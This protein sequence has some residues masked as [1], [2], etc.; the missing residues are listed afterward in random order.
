MAFKCSG[1]R[2]CLGVN[3]LWASRLAMAAFCCPYRCPHVE[4]IEW[5]ILGR[6]PEIVSFTSFTM[7]ANCP[8]ELVRRQ[9]A[10]HC[11]LCGHIVVLKKTEERKPD[12]IQGLC[13]SRND[14]WSLYLAIACLIFRVTEWAGIVGCPS[15]LSCEQYQE[16]SEQFFH[17]PIHR[18]VQLSGRSQGCWRFS[19]LIFWS[20]H[21]M[22][23]Y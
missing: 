15:A 14:T 1:R 8:A 11:C 3:A 9:G 7:R 2:T 17:L 12:S 20:S 22:S 21:A 18:G 6:K 16:R 13:N 5:P 10:G 19:I 23:R 4:V